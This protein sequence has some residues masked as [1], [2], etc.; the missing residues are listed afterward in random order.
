MRIAPPFEGRLL[1]T[2]CCRDTYKAKSSQVK[3]TILAVNDR[4]KDKL[5]EVT[6]DLEAQLESIKAEAARSAAKAKAHRPSS[7]IADRLKLQEECQ[8]IVAE[9]WKS[10]T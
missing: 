4:L 6:A 10:P 1:A 7:H 2:L 5:A 3:D 9:R 8:E